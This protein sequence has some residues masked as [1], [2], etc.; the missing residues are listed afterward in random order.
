MTDTFLF[1][2]GFFPSF[3]R[4]H[5]LINFILFI[6]LFSNIF[7]KNKVHIMKKYLILVEMLNKNTNIR[8]SLTPDLNYFSIHIN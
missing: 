1:D 7:Y 6:N 4:S 2:L 5:N 3:N 8:F